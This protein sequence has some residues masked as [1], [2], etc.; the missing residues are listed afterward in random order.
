[1]NYWFTADE[2]YDHKNIIKFCDRPFFDVEEMNETLIRNHNEVVQE[3]DTV[4][5]AGDFALTSKKRAGE[6]IQQLKGNHIFLQGSHDKWGSNLPFL[7]EKQIEDI[8]VVVCHYPMLSWPRSYHGSYLLHAHTHCRLRSYPGIL[9]IGVD[10]WDFYPAD[11]K[12]IRT[13][14]W[15]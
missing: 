12:T 10:C 2:H 7:W 1:M 11:F 15:K 13:K 9:D 4:I 14:I 8:Y 3:D 5:H 6:I